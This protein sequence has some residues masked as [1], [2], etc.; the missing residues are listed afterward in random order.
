MLPAEALQRSGTHTVGNS[1]CGEAVRVDLEIVCFLK[2]RNGRSLRSP[3]VQR[4]RPSRGDPCPRGD[5][6]RAQERGPSPPGPEP[7][8][9]NRRPESCAPKAPFHI[10][11]QERQPPRRIFQQKKFFHSN[12]VPRRRPFHPALAYRGKGTRVGLNL[13]TNHRLPPGPGAL[14][15]RARRS[16]TVRPPGQVR[17]PTSLRSRDTHPHKVILN[18]AAS[19]RPSELME[20]GRAATPPA[21]PPGTK[22]RF[23]KQGRWRR[24]GELG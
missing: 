13:E 22:S 12:S 20:P 23:S 15:P 21:A 14:S 19:E 5:R 4:P 7:P 10:P 1:L 2:L 3:T 16:P 18:H 17:P 9:S 24:P 8:G 11:G 6:S